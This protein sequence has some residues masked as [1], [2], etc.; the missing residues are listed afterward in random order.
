MQIHSLASMTE[1]Y[2]WV[3]Q[4]SFLCILC[5][6]VDSSTDSSTLLVAID[7]LWPSLVL[8][9]GAVNSRTFSDGTTS[10]VICIPTKTVPHSGLVL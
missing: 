8:E 4:L 3:M 2:S 1:V 7:H 5:H 10:L 9:A 6:G